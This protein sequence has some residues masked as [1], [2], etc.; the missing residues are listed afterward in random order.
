MGDEALVNLEA[1][2]VRKD[3]LSRIAIAGMKASRV[4]FDG[5]ESMPQTILKPELNDPNL[6]F[7]SETV[8][9]AADLLP[10]LAIE[11]RDLPDTLSDSEKQARIVGYL[12]R[13]TLVSF[14]EDNTKFLYDLRDI[15][16][17]GSEANDLPPSETDEERAKRVLEAI[18]ISIDTNNRMNETQKYIY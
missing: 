4:G 7:V 8:L 13:E 3:E 10:E 12:A 5:D 18:Q 2:T 1:L 14:S 16:Y 9:M 6:R 11:G 17:G 15:G